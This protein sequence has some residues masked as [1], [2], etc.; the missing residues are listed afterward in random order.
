MTRDSRSR[1]LS[2]PSCSMTSLLLLRARRAMARSV[3]TTLAPSLLAS[4]GAMVLLPMPG[5]PDEE[6]MH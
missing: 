3:S 6:E 5:G 1:K 4:S 2:I